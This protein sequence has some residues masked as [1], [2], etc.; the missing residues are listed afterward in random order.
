MSD[1]T[2]DTEDAIGDALFND[3]DFPGVTTLYVG[4]HTADPGNN[5]DGSTE[6]GAADYDRVQTSPS[7]WSTS[8]NAPRTATNDN[9]VE[10]AEA[11]NDWGTITHIVVWDNEQGATGETPYT[12]Y[13][14]DSSVEINAGDILRFPAGDITFDIN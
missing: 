6:V 3:T 5:P 1:F 12:T 14:L 8:G 4:A 2:D 13:A 10:F 7:E 9:D 11:E